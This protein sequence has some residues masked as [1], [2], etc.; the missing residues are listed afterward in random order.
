MVNYSTILAEGLAVP[1]RGYLSGLTLSTAGSS[2]TFS[3]AAGMATDD[4]PKEYMSLGSSISK[5]TSAWAVGTSNGALDTGAIANSTWY[6]VYLIKRPDTGVVDALVS[7]SASAPTMPTNYTL[8]RRIGSMKTNGSAQWASFTQLGDEFLWPTSVNDVNAATPTS[9]NR[10]L[11]TLSVP[12]GVQVNALFRFF[13]SGLASGSNSILTSPDETD[14]V[15][16][17]AGAGTVDLRVNT[18][19]DAVAARFN[20]RTDTSARIGYRAQSAVG[21]VNIGTFGW[22]DTRGKL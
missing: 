21:S 13:V 10:T 20:I 7:L 5:T 22:V 4:T 1:L 2:A 18:A 16:T 11:Y 9:A 3:V 14:Q 12:T 19:G 17:G 15:A 8:K 6:H